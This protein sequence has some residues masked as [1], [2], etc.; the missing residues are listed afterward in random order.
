MPQA[1]KENVP[2]R[3]NKKNQSA[4]SLQI[5]Y[6]FCVYT[7]NVML[8]GSPSGI[9]TYFPWEKFQLTNEE[10]K[11]LQTD[12]VYIDKHFNQTGWFLNK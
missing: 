7:V 5:F 10:F 2:M 9:I 6:L 3:W 8:Y 12:S 11:M 1:G 4:E